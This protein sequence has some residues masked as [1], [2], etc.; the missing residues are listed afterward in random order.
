MKKFKRII[1]SLVEQEVK[2]RMFE[3]KLARENRRKQEREKEKKDR[4]L[5]IQKLKEQHSRE[6]RQ[7]KAKYERK[8]IFFLF[9]LI[10]VENLKICIKKMLYF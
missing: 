3:E 7:L 4:E 8:N 9:F 6:L 1:N 10:S 5:E 2:R